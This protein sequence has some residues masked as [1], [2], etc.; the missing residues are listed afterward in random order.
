MKLVI[1]ESPTKAKTISKFLG[2]GFTVKS[3]F[4]H[5]RDLPKS[6]MGVDVTKNFEPR[7]VIPTASRKVVTDLRKTAAKAETIVFATDEDREGEAISWHLREI[8]KKELGEKFAEK[9]LERIA[10]HEIT[11]EAIHEALEHPRELD[12]HLVDAQQARRILDRLVGYELSPLLWQKVA[13]GL[14]AGRVQSVALRLVV[15]RAREIQAF[16]AEEYWTIEG[17]FAKLEVESKK[18]EV[19]AAK[20]VKIGDTA[21]E[22]FSIRTEAEAKSI[23]DAL[24]GAAFRIASVVKKTSHRSPA[25]PFTTSTLQ[26]EANKKLGFSAKQTMVIAQ[27]LYEG[28]KLGAE[29]SVGL[30]TYMRTDAVS[31]SER[32]LA[33]AR[34]L[35]KKEFGESATPDAPRRYKARSRLAQEAHEAVRPTAA[36]RTPESIKQYLEPN[37]AKLYDLIWRRAVASQMRDAE[38]ETTSV[39][40]LGGEKYVFRAAGTRIAGEGYL[41]LFPDAER[42]TVLPELHEGEAVTAHEVIPKQHFTEP[43]ARYSDASLVK[44]LEEYGIGRPSTYA[45]TIATILERGYAE[46]VEGRRLA[47]TDIAYVVNDLLVEHFPVIVDHHFTA[48]MEEEL[49]EIAEGKKEWVPV[50]EAFYTPFSKTLAEKRE[51]L[52]KKELTETPTDEKCDLCGRPMVIKLGRYG[53]FYACTGFPECRGTKPLKDSAR[54]VPIDTGVTCPT[55]EKGTIVERRSRRGKKFWGCGT[56]PACTFV[57]WKKPTGAKC[58]TCSSLIVLGAKEKVYCSNPECPAKKTATKTEYNQKTGQRED[59]TPKP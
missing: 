24:A 58:E 37:Q 10:F 15:E 2:R 22:K 57:L 29:G 28:I 56:Y 34:T 4:G 7:Y 59:R 36:Q 30:I 14:S 18:L 9:K 51:L 21:L 45:P 41:A 26:Q 12:L 48:K 17:V 27:Q 25:P 20:L 19:F 40:V 3:S 6:E 11:E 42:G 54:A 52:V 46:R 44:T 23:L 35:I 39:D 5:I 43:P 32:F 8:F 33:E 50:I 49:D 1:V 38:L 55:C 16:K 13:R 47:P 31:L 53:K